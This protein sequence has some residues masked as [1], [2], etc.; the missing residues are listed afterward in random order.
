MVSDRGCV[1][2]GGVTRLGQ[3]APLTPQEVKDFETLVQ[4]IIR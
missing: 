2:V 4:G 3:Q 1:L